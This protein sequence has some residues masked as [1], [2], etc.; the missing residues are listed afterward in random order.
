MIKKAVLLSLSL[1]ATPMAF[2]ISEID[3]ALLSIG[4]V[5]ENYEY[6]DEALATEFFRLTTNEVAKSLPSRLNVYI[7][8]DSA[9]MT[10]YSGRFNAVYTIPFTPSEREVV[11]QELSSIETLQET[12]LDYYLPNKFM[13]ANDFNLIYAFHD[14]N[15][16][17]LANVRMNVLTC[18]DALTR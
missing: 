8:L 12:C 7:K 3:E 6:T 18:Y 16:R 10:P 1:L 15:Y 9:L 2:A 4:L 11:I 17:P 5:D 13:V 14:E